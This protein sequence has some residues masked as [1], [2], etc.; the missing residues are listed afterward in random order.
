MRVVERKTSDSEKYIGYSINSGRC[1]GG[2]ERHG[3]FYN[4]ESKTTG[5]KSSCKC[6]AGKKP[7]VV[8][9]P[10]SGAGTTGLVAARFNRDYIGIEINPK[11]VKRSKK[12]LYNDEPLFYQEVL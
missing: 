4:H 6:S 3:G 7:G 12:R 5:F 9:D 1:D 10:F 2:G 11:D 8:L